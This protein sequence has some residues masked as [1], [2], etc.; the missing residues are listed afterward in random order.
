MNLLDQN[1][2][3]VLNSSWVVIATKSVADSLTDVAKGAYFALD[4]QDEHMIPATWE[5]WIAL[6]VRDGDDAV[7]T[8]KLSIRIPRVIVA[9]GYRKVPVRRLKCSLKNLRRVHNDTCAITGRRLK[10]SE[11]SREHVTPVSLGGKN[12][13]ENEVLAHKDINSR[14]GNMPYESVGLRAPVIPPAP[15]EKPAAAT[16]ENRFGFPEWDLLLGRKS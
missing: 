1:R 11:M 9:K 15:R 12:G 4:I 8:T 2:V 3:L 16:I 6:P 10:P 13:W 5:Q 7:H 14:R